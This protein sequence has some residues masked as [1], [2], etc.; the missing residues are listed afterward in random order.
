VQS[1]ACFA[2][3]WAFSE[4]WHSPGTPQ[5]IV[6]QKLTKIAA[7][8]PST[9][10][11]ALSAR[12]GVLQRELERGSGLWR[13]AGLAF[14]LLPVLE[15]RDKG[16]LHGTPP[17]LHPILPQHFKPFH[18]T[19]RRA[20]AASHTNEPAE[21][22]HKRAYIQNKSLAWHGE[23]HLFRGQDRYV[24]PDAFF[25]PRARHCFCL[26]AAPLFGFEASPLAGHLL[27][28]WPQVRVRPCILC[29]RPRFSI[30]SIIAT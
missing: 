1:T 16:I 6:Q 11:G 22:P 24:Q 30:V 4:C 26:S 10:I 15:C 2:S 19:R 20:A 23:S 9:E 27:R 5:F 25:L 12:R 28:F 21:S 8:R 18:T 29:V 13:F 7:P 14:T 3:T 17:H